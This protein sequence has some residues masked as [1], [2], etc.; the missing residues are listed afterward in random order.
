[1]LLSV[2]LNQRALLYFKCD[3]FR[4]VVTGVAIFR[5]NL[6]AINPRDR[7][8]QTKSFAALVDTGSH[9]TWLPKEALID[10]G[11]EPEGKKSFLTATKQKTIRDYGYAILATDNYTTNCEVV[12][13]EMNDQI[14]LGVRTIEGF[15]V[16]IDSI[17][18]RFEPVERFVTGITLIHE[19]ED[20]SS[21]S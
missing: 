10:I 21:Q 8:K 1:M 13:G 7:S 15:G 12:F 6:K 9:M 14:L 3:Y 17:N 11:I 19:G 4:E 16:K 20:D 18:G 5:V 2:K